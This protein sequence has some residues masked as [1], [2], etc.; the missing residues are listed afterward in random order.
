MFLYFL[1][2][3]FFFA[4]IV[5][6]TL[7]IKWKLLEK[8]TSLLDRLEK[9]LNVRKLVF[10]SFFRGCIHSPLWCIIHYVYIMLCIHCIDIIWW[11]ILTGKNNKCF[12]CF[13]DTFAFNTSSVCEKEDR[14]RKMLFWYCKCDRRWENRRLEWCKEKEPFPTPNLGFLAQTFP[15]KSKND[16]ERKSY[17][18]SS[19]L[20]IGIISYHVAKRRVVFLA[21]L[22]LSFPTEEEYSVG[23]TACIN[24]AYRDWKSI[25]DNLKKDL[26]QQHHQTLMTKMISFVSTYDD[27]NKRIDH[28]CLTTMKR[29]F[30]EIAII[31]S[32][33]KS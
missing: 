12:N 10:F 23:A 16:Y 5:Y 31:T 3:V 2:K 18:E 4:K 14:R 8:K 24:E 7:Y 26:E 20:L 32:L 11:I 27:P 19:G 22:V 33:I 1:T 21:D 17:R 25:H 30:E 28:M 15:D 13:V 9:T 6:S 29:L